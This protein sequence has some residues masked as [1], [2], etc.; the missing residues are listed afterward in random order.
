MTHD[1]LLDASVFFF[2]LWSLVV[3]A[4]SIAAFGRDLLPVQVRVEPRNAAIPESKDRQSQYWP[5]NHY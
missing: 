3:G 5:V 4:I 1:S 2:A